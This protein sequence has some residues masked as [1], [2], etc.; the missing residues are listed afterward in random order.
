MKGIH[1]RPRRLSGAV[2]TLIAAQRGGTFAGVANY[3]Y[4]RPSLVGIAGTVVAIAMMALSLV[5]LYNGRTDALEHSRETS[6]NLV[7]VIGNDVARNM[8][9]Y[10]LSLQ[11]MVDDAFAPGVDT[12]PPLFR[13][14]VVFDRATHAGYLSGA[15]VFNTRG[16]AVL[17]RD[18]DVARKLDASQREFFIHHKNDSSMATYVSH[19]FFSHVANAGPTITMSRRINGPDHAFAGVASIGLRIELFRSLLDRVSTGAHGATFIVRRDGTL[20]V[21]KPF[22]PADIGSSIAASPMFAAM[23][24]DEHGTYASSATSD[25]VRRLYTF[26]RIPGTPFIAVV[27]PAEEDVLAPWR[28]RTVLVGSLTLLFGMTFIALSWALVGMMRQHAA[29]QVELARL[30]GTDGLTGLLNRRAFDL[31]INDAWAHA[32]REGFPLSA[33]FVDIDFFKLFNDAY[34]HAVG[35]DALIAVSDC[36]EASI[37]KP[38]DIA[39]RYGGEEFVVVLPA[40]ASDVAQAIAERLRARVAAAGIAHEMGVTEVLTVSIGCATAFPAEGNDI[41]ELLA[42][43]DRALYKAKSAGRN[44]VAVTELRNNGATRTNANAQLDA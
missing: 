1:S 17:D 23:S 9:V 4:A 27:A 2:G 40:T 29:T 35:D 31:R 37:R 20:V 38:G 36:I 13:R 10:E 24:A 30:A 12:L 7:G 11:A 32:R 25:G 16:I 21:R 15:F 43:A 39:A 5:T 8:E 6:E 41:V 22:N 14:Q 26:A 28:R 18:S 33:L 3:L 19:P 42:T 34:G 44:R